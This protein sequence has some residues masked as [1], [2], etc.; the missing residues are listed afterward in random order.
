MEKDRKVTV[1]LLQYFKTKQDL[2]NAA[3]FVSVALL[4]YFKT[5][6]DDMNNHKFVAIENGKRLMSDDEAEK[7]EGIADRAQV[8]V[9]ESVSVKG[10]SVVTTTD[11][12]VEIDLDLYVKKGDISTVLRYKGTVAVLDDLPAEGQIVGDLYNITNADAVHGVN[13]GDN[14]VWN[15]SSWDNLAGMV[16]L[17]G[18]VDKSDGKS[19]VDNLEIVKLSGVSE[20]ANK[21]EVSTVSFTKGTKIGTVTIDGTSADLF[22]PSVSVTA[23]KT[24]G[25]KIATISIDGTD[26]DIYID[27]EKEVIATWSAVVG[28]PDT[29]PPSEHTH[30]QYLT[31]VPVKKDSDGNIYFE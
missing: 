10:E 1:E 23:D 8:N 15:G 5:Q 24:S 17:S 12:A 30:A 31:S 29:F 3:K 20:G 22:T 6:Q 11:K 7:L 4:Q 14:L 28:K 2:A 21:T 27:A 13:A 19:L 9:I 25:V 18:K 26:T 16:D